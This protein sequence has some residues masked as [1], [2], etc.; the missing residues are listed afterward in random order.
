MGTG[1]RKKSGRIF[2]GSKL[3]VEG[4]ENFGSLTGKLKKFVFLIKQTKGEPGPPLTPT[5][6]VTPTNT[7][8]PSLT[9][10][11]T[12]TPSLTQTQTPTPSLTQTQTPTNTQTQTPTPSIT[13]TVT[14]TNTQTPTQTPTNTITPTN[15]QTVTPTEIS[16]VCYDLS[17]ITGAPLAPPLSYS[18][19]S[20]S[21]GAITGSML[22]NTTTRFCAKQN[23]ISAPGISIGIDTPFCNAG[24]CPT[25]TPTPTPSITLTNTQTQTPT[26]TPSVTQT[27]T[28]TPTNTQTTTNT[29]TP[30]PSIT[31]TITPT[32]TT[33]PTPTIPE[34]R[35]WYLTN[36]TAGALNYNYND[37]SGTV[38]IGNINAGESIQVCARIVNE[39][40]S[41][42]KANYGPCT[43]GTCNNE[44]FY[45]F[46]GNTV[47]FNTGYCNSYSAI[48]F[49]NNPPSS[50]GLFSGGTAF[51]DVNFNLRNNTRNTIPPYFY[52]VVEGVVS[53][54]A[55]ACTRNS[56]TCVTN[57]YRLE[58]TG[59]TAT[60][61]MS[62]PFVDAPTSFTLPKNY[63]V[64]MCLC[65]E[66]T[67]S[68]LSVTNLGSCPY[69]IG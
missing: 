29:Q 37:C 32:Q 52:Q 19:I 48:T 24:V 21:G 50:Q 36:P 54:S 4:Q 20:C 42:I 12:P 28:Q 35:C 31:S 11:Q 49:T 61:S 25:P 45:G 2:T 66:P 62:P 6:S 13:Q 67:G 10:T 46:F 63:V 30:T 9:Q 44:T 34:C 56:G 17:Y 57:Q 1:D 38:F 53:T 59:A 65:S 5:P 39:D 8:T 64:Y 51:L 68:N 16:C 27:Q 33:T 40:I 47:P 55:S 14:T 18:G 15:T 43:G 23:S 69:N 22:P 26:P 41:I 58:A 7:P 60:V 3:I